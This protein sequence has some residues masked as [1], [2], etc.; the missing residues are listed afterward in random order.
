VIPGDG[1][2]VA[3][4]MAEKTYDDPNWGDGPIA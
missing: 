2:T 4:Q 3:N 1:S